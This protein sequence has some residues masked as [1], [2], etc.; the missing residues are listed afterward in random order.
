MKKVLVLILALGF[1]TSTFANQPERSP[2]T[3]VS[4]GVVFGWGDFIQVKNS[5]YW[6]ASKMTYVTGVDGK[7]YKDIIKELKDIHG[8]K[9]KCRFANHFVE[10]MSEVGVVVGE[11]VNLQIYL[12]S[13]GHEVIEVNNVPTTVLNARRVAATNNYCN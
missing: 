5:K 6:D 2:F 1:I 12:F 8:K 9:W 11:T 3:S 13:F 4:Y 10:S 7:D